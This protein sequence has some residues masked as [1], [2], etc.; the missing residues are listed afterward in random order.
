[1]KYTLEFEE[2]IE[3]FLDES[4]FEPAVFNLVHGTCEDSLTETLMVEVLK[5]LG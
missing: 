1:M 3:Q 5:R 2:S 4:D